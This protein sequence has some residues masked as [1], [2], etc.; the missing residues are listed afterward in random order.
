VDGEGLT[1]HVVCEA[2][3]MGFVIYRRLQQLGIYGIVVAPTKT[4]L[5][6]RDGPRAEPSG[7]A[8]KRN[9]RAPP[10]A[11]PARYPMDRRAGH[12]SRKHNPHKRT[13]P[14]TVIRDGLVQPASRCALRRSRTL[15]IRRFHDVSSTSTIITAFAG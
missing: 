10:G 12:V 1:L 4:R 13:A 6:R 9:R 11:A 15:G 14:A 7:A 2:G 5:R 8:P 3:P